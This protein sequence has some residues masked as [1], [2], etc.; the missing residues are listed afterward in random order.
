[1]D[2]MN[3]GLLLSGG[4]ISMVGLAVFLYGKKMES[5]NSL[6]FGLAMM[7]FLM[8]IT[9]ILWMWLIAI[10]CIAALFILSRIG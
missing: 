9:S 1:M 3:P 4:A 6:G 7:V 10:A 2:F 8:F 5:I